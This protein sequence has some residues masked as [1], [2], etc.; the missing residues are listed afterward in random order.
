[1]LLQYK[2]L[3]IK[4]LLSKHFK[5]KDYTESIRQQAMSGNIQSVITVKETFQS[6]SAENTLKRLSSTAMTACYFQPCNVDKNM[7][8][9]LNIALQRKSFLTLR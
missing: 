7:D 3:V 1:M 9:K 8:P 2:C 5:D 4:V 6:I